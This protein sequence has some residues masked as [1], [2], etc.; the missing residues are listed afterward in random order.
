MAIFPP[1]VQTGITNLGVSDAVSASGFHYAPDPSSQG[2]ST[3][4]GNVATNAGGPHTLKYGVTGNHVLGVEAGLGDGSI[5]KLGPIHQPASFDLTGV[6]VGSE[7]TLGIVTRVWV[8]LTPN[9][10]AFRTMRAIFESVDDATGAI[11]DIIGAGII[12]AA[13]ELMDQGIVAAVEEAFHF[14]F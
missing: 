9:P 8:R 10:E 5:V 4:G 6:L 12:P 3:I 14:G 7:G 2:A 13:M 1:I 11:S